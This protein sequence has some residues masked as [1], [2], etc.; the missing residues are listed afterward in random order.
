MFWII[1]IIIG[2]L[3]F[4]LIKLIT[5]QEDDNIFDEEDIFIPVFFVIG[6]FIPVLNWIILIILSIYFM[7]EIKWNKIFYK[8]YGKKRN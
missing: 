2:I 7:S 3:D 1:C 6:P 8:I 5:K 4:I